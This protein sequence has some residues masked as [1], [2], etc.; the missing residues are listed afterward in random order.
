MFFR[1]F[2]EL[3]KSNMVTIL[4]FDSQCIKRLL[5]RNEVG[6][7]FPLFFKSR[8]KHKNHTSYITAIDIALENNQLRAAQ[9]IIDYIT[10]WQNSFAFNFLFKD[11]FVQLLKKGINVKELV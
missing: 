2:M 6:H 10:K 9:S 7:D 5:E 1:C 11:N 3:D 8:K 4:S